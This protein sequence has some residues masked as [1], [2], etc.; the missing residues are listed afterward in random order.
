MHA[1]D[2]ITKQTWKSTYYPRVDEFTRLELVGTAE[3]GFTSNPNLTVWLEFPNYPNQTKLKDLPKRVYKHNVED[4]EKPVVVLYYTAIVLLDQGNIVDFRWDDGCGGCA[5]K[6][7]IDEQCGAEI[8]KDNFCSEETNC[9]IKVYLVW[10]GRDK[11][12]AKCRSI[13]SRPNSF[14]KYSVTPVTNF[15][16]SLFSSTIFNFKSN[17]PNPLSDQ[18]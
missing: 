12:D 11:D 4:E 1:R 14:S 7:C 16:N 18:A 2:N 6:L 10:M 5:K 15:G 8:K 3:Q 13:S 17:A 9:N